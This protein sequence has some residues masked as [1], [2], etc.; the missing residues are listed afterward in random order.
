MSTKPRIIA[1]TASVALLAAAGAGAAVVAL[2]VA[3]SGSNQ[4]QL[5]ASTTDAVPSPQDDRT[6]VYRSPQQS[7]DHDDDH[8][9]DDNYSQRLKPAPPSTGYNGGQTQKS[10]GNTSKSS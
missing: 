4:T 10:P 3:D 1:T 6:T 5:D 7:D 2:D 9:S 8:G